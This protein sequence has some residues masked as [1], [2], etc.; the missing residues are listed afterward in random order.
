MAWFL[1]HRSSL[2][3]AHISYLSPSP[4]DHAHT[5]GRRLLSLVT[6]PQLERILPR[7]L[8]E[9]QFLSPFG[10]RSLSREHC[11]RPY[12]F[13]TGVRVIGCVS[14]YVPARV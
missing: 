4:S 10:L 13:A 8:D 5:H 11:D 12:T 2:V 9:A 1:R 7:M 6:R 14:V 3:S